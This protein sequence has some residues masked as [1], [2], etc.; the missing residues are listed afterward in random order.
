MKR[1]GLIVCALCAVGLS[2]TDAQID[3][4][5][6]PMPGTDNPP[7]QILAEKRAA[8]RAFFDKQLANPQAYSKRALAESK[9]FPEGD[10]F[11]FVLPAYA[12]TSLAIDKEIEPDAAQKR[13]ADLI[14]LSIPAVARNARVDGRAGLLK[15][16]HYKQRTTYLAHLN[17]AMACYKR[18]GG[19]KRFDDLHHHLTQL[20]HNAMAEQRGKYLKTFPWNDWPFET[21]PAM[22][23][24]YMVDQRTGKNEHGPLIDKHLAW[25][26]ANAFDRRLQLPWSF[27]DAR[28][29]R[30]HPPRGCALSWRVALTAH[31]D[32]DEAKRIYEPYCKHY[33]L[34]R[35]ELTGF[36]E[37]PAGSGNR[38]ADPDSGPILFDVGGSATALGVGATIA[39]N[40]QTRLAALARQ[41]EVMPELMPLLAVKDSRDG[42]RKIAGIVEYDPRYVSGFLYGDCTLFH[43]LNWTDWSGPPIA[44]D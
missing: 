12:Y 2:Q 41:L 23:S 43:S 33:W 31:F 7:K 40:D 42:K 17:L 14:E 24:L 16:K 10:L 28:N 34:E 35:S 36:R 13:V 15:L 32:R 5:R 1:A 44:P 20:L 38:R 19:D 18:I 9:G 27:V 21:V 8:L 11:P 3:L 29:G 4:S 30:T 37:Y 22:L 39:M 6:L 25:L 26:R